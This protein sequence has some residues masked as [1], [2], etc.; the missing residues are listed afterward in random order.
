MSNFKGTDIDDIL[1]LTIVYKIM[2]KGC[3]FCFGFMPFSEWVKPSETFLSWY[4]YTT[5][6]YTKNPYSRW[7]VIQYPNDFLVSS[8]TAVFVVITL[9][10]GID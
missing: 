10:N 7:S 9:I 3:R 4:L 2:Y 6:L 8:V 5:N 1:F